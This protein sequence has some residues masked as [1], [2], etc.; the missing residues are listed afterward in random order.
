MKKLAFVTMLAFSLSACVTA[1]VLTP[2]EQ[3]AVFGKQQQATAAWFAAHPTWG[4]TGRIAVSAPTGSGS[5]RLEWTNRT[6][7]YVASVAAPIT[8]Q[9]WRLTQRNG[10]GATVEGIPNGPLSGPNAEQLLFD[11]SGWRI[12]LDRLQQWLK[13][14]TPTGGAIQLDPQTG[15]PASF[16]EGQWSV[17]YDEW[18]PANDTMPAMPKRITAT[19]GTDTKVKLA[20]D[21]WEPVATTD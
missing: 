3:Q 17:V 13:G 1:P 4:M 6:D 19:I 14:M 21:A 8:R 2:S 11:V 10:Y 5:G 16:R 18:T 9:T 12:P 20:I 7:G 15:L